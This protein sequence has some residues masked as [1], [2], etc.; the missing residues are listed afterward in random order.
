MSTGVDPYAAAR[1]KTRD[2]FKFYVS[3][4]VGLGAAM[5]G[6]LSFAILPDLSGGLLWGAV[7]CGAAAILAVIYGLW[8]AHGVLAP[9][10]FDPARLA[11]GDL[12]DR[13]APF[14]PSLLP[15]DA[16]TPEALDAKLDALGQVD[17]MTAG[18]VADMDRLTAERTKLHG[19]A[20][21]LELDAVAAPARRRLLGAFAAFLVLAAAVTILS[22][23]AEARRKVGETVPMTFTG[24]WGGYVEALSAACPLP[25]PRGLAAEGVAG[26]PF[27]GWVTATVTGQPCAGVTFSAPA[28]LFARPE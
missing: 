22:G 12:R 8:T 19:F 23:I 21:A 18:I 26:K 24:G 27:E 17:P 15:A 2:A 1:D 4:L 7:A 13:L 25:H 20:A 14:L 16:R 11:G 28:R 5:A 10:P 9:R 3:A 6:G